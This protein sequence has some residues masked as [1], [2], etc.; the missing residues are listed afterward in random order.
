MLNRPQI[1]I[2]FRIDHMEG[3]T[4]EMIRLSGEISPYVWDTL[5]RQAHKKDVIQFTRERKVWLL[6]WIAQ[7]T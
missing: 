6:T 7:Q 4:Q 3:V 5:K 2:K 1:Q